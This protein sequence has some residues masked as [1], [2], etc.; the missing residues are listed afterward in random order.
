MAPRTTK[1]PGRAP[2]AA[3]FGGGGAFGY[4][5][6]MGIADGLAERG[7]DVGRWPMIGTS[8]GAHAAA[9]IDT[10]L[11]FDH[12]A[13]LW[14]NALDGAS[15]WRRFRGIDLSG[16]IY[17]ERGTT[18]LGAVAVRLLTLR[19]RVL[20]SDEYPLADIVAASSSVLPI[21][22]PHLID[23]RRYVDGGTVSLASIDLAPPADLLIAVT[24]FGVRGQGVAGRLGEF[25]ARRETRAWHG[26]HGGAVLH[27][28]P[29]AE[30]AALG[31][32][33]LRDLGDM[34][35]GRAVYPLA[36]DYGR[37]VGDVVRR[38]HPA[39]VERATSPG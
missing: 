5:F 3:C 9:T 8:A 13:A 19:R 31:G 23:G 18:D 6:N 20:R 1:P 16:P 26:R 32:G 14:A 35:I 17:G 33:R 21:V 22:R 7:F 27:V 39:L 29:S 4:G 37:H 2:I 15:R 38:D 36:V 11:D 25:Q 34:A 10:A 12:V 24:P 28:V 30:M